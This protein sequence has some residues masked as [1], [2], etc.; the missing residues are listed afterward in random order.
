[1]STP[2]QLQFQSLKDQH[3]DAILFFQLG[4]F[5]E[6][7][8]EDAQIGARVL[9]INL[10][11]RHRG[12]ENEMPMCGMPMKAADDYIQKLVSAGYRVA[13]AEQVTDEDGKIS[14][15]INRVVS[16]GAT[17]EDGMLKPDENAFLV[18]FSKPKKSAD[19]LYTL[20]VADLS[21]GDLRVCGCSDEES[22][23]DELYKINPREILIPSEIY[24][25]ENWCAKLPKC[26]HTPRAIDDQKKSADFLKKHFSV[27]TLDSFGI[28]NTEIFAS[29][30]ALILQFLSA[31]QGG[32]LQHFQKLV[33]YEVGD[34]MVLDQQTL[35]HLEIFWPISPLQKEGTLLS[36]FEKPATAMGGRCLRQWLSRPLVN[37]DEIAL[38]HAAVAEIH[39]DYTLQQNLT[40]SL[41]AIFD[42]ERLLAR[43]TVNRGNARDLVFLKESLRVLPKLA[44]HCRAASAQKIREKSETLTVFEDLYELLEKALVENP[45]LEI[46]AGG[47]IKEGFR[48]KLD[49]L[50]LLKKSAD[51]WLDQFLETKKKESGIEKLRIKFSKTFGFCLE[52]STAAA[53]NAPADWVRRQ[54]LVNAERFT[55]PEL[56]EYENKVLSAET[57]SFALEHEIFLELR[58]EVLK[59]TAQIQA[60]STALA[61]LDVLLLFAKTAQRWRWNQPEISKKSADF[62][63]KNGRHPVVEKVSESTFIANSLGMKSSSQ[64]H[65]ITGPNMAGKSTYLRQNALIILLAQIGSFVPAES[66]KMGIFDRIFTRVG[67]SDNLAAG[68]STFFVEMAETARILNAATE[69]S[70]II[71]D[72]IGRGTSTFDGISIAWAITEYLH[73]TIK[74]KTIFATHYHEMIDCV[75]RL[76]N[77]QNFHV[78]VTQND[79]EIIFLRKI[80]P[81]GISDS[82]GIEVAASTGFPKSVIVRSK[83][84]LSELESHEPTGDQPSLF[85][86]K[87]RVV[88]KIVE[89]NSAV[90]QRLKKIEPDELAPKDALE[91]LYE[92]KRLQ[93]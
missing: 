29:A 86:A 35:T 51:N 87:P 34:A 26:L 56:A 90:E 48:P 12:T 81:G 74:A 38:R 3:P 4:E 8:Y 42:L 32:S 6:M 16:P 25:D 15:Q 58:T 92:L 21:T 93:G 27:K 43:L 66:V 13:V 54:T 70:F 63:V 1:M 62:L 36:V 37:Y 45:P 47:M 41:S 31:T 9:G 33:R 24:A 59:Y 5:Y 91:L 76:K 68:K 61:E 89:K 73:D 46:T 11:A 18:S 79:E 75:E 10:T 30:P 19:F 78:S 69:R 83:E 2:V 80:L 67:A 44:T 7:F 71:L 49:E 40:E 65:L 57:E 55:T 53:K 22:F 77:A 72:E 88:E 20:A 82:F 14:R 28:E 52:A 84:I 60:A 64:F 85:T 17:V 23:F 50:L 39:T